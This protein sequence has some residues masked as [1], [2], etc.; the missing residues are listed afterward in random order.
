MAST[1]VTKS[2][3][4]I[5]GRTVEQYRITIPKGLA[6]ALQLEGARMEWEVDS[7]NTLRLTRV[8]S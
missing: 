6:E 1:K 5:D 4:E 2:T 8:D 7:A 3:S